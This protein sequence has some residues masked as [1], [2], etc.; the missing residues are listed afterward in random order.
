MEFL[1]EAGAFSSCRSALDTLI[2][3]ER[4]LPQQVFKSTL[5]R[6]VFLSS[7]DLFHTAAF[8]DRIK[9]FLARIG[10]QRSFLAVVEPDPVDYFFPHFGKYSVVEMSVADT[11][12]DYLRIMQ[13]DPGG[14][15]ADAIGYN[16]RIVVLF[17][18]SRRWAIYADRDFELA[19]AAFTEGQLLQVFTTVYDSNRLFEVNEAI[20]R[21]IKPIYS[22]GVPRVFTDFTQQ[23]VNNYGTP[24][25]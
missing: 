6:F 4:H 5:S 20:E 15:P 16:S 11:D 9:S 1:T 10:E 22:H 21:L 25:G 2:V 17:S 24:N 3:R 13:E 14:S 12:E 8:F 18:T 7:D 19:I 23:L